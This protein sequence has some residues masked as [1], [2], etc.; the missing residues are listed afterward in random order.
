MEL[1]E[2]QTR[3][4]GGQ[5]FAKGVAAMAMAGVKA[6]Q[7]C[8]FCDL[9][10]SMLAFDSASFASCLL[11]KSQRSV[12]GNNKSLSRSLHS[13]I[14]SSIVATLCWPEWETWRSEEL[15]GFFAF[16]ETQFLVWVGAG[17]Q[18]FKASRFGIRVNLR[19]VLALLVTF[20][21]FRV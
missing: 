7:D 15:L 16:F 18:I 10:G 12:E 17:D 5:Q 11:C 1:W 9:C 6:Q 4:E 8:L 13:P 2:G 14:L 3:E 21:G 20:L 19:H